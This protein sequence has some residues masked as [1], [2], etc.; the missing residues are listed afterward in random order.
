MSDQ[1]NAVAREL[2]ETPAVVVVDPIAP[3]LVPVSRQAVLKLLLASVLG[4]VAAG[5]V[6]AMRGEFVAQPVR[7]PLEVSSAA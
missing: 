3:V 1:Q 6:L 7:G 5:V 2:T 4:M